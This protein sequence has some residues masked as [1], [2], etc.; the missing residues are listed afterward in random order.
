MAMHRF[1]ISFVFLIGIFSCKQEEKVNQIP[2]EELSNDLALDHFNIWVKEPQKAKEKLEKL[3]FISVPDSLST[4]H[5][6]QGT[7]GKYFYFLNTYL[8]F[9]YVYDEEEFEENNK[10]NQELDF[11]ERVNF[12]ENGTS[13]FG[14]ALKV[15]DYDVEKIPFKKVA[16]HQDWMEEDAN[17]YAAKSSKTNLK[18]PSVFVVYPQIQY[19]VFETLN[20]LQRIPEEYAIWREFYKQPNGAKKV[21]E[22]VITSKDVDLTTETMQALNAIGNVAIKTGADY[23]M[24]LHFDNDEQGKTF[25]LRPEIPLKIYL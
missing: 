25:D 3:G 2:Q 15:K 12:Q 24:E 21:T 9:I 18:E 22:L 1:I 23:L 11:A 14:I 16:Y 5:H 20:D 4:V 13:P 7:T 17:I 10:Q 6:G 8:E 19:D